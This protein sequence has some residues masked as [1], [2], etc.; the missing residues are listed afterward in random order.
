MVVMKRGKSGGGGG[1]GRDDL[2]LVVKIVEQRLDF[3]IVP[4]AF[5]TA[6][7]DGSRGVVV[8]ETF[9]VGRFDFYQIEP[10]LGQ[11]VLDGHVV[12]QFGADFTVLF[13]YLY[14]IDWEKKIHSHFN[15][16]F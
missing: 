16:S 7:G 11:V 8:G 13:G 3:E 4:N 10:D 1:G 12:A 6:G 5:E 14:S 15:S 2:G 9:V